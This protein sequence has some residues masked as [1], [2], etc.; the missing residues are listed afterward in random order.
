MAE[1]APALIDGIAFELDVSDRIWLFNIM[2]REGNIRTLRLVQAL[3][4]TIKVTKEELQGLQQA[5]SDANNKG[6]SELN[7]ETHTYHFDKKTVEM[8]EATL[9]QLSAQGKLRFDCIGLYNKFV[10]EREKK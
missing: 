6:E 10:K 8:I 9:A 4:P 5:Q 7:L 3:L 1:A 2:P